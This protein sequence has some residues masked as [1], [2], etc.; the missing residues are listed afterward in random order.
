M[1][2]IANVLPDLSAITSVTGLRDATTDS[3][4][5][6]LSTGAFVDPISSSPAS[7]QP[8]TIVDLSDHAKAVLAR[9]KTEQVAAD[10]LDAQVRASSSDAL[11]SNLSTTG[12]S[13]EKSTFDQIHDLGREL[14]TSGSAPNAQTSDSAGKD[15]LGGTPIWR[16]TAAADNIAI[17]QAG[18]KLYNRPQEMEDIAKNGGQFASPTEGHV[19]SDDVLFVFTVHS[20]IALNISE[21]RE[22]GMTDQ[23]Q[24][25]SDA[26]QNGKL[27]FQKA[28][29]VPDLN[30]KSWMIHFADAGG[31]G[32]MGSS[33]V[34]PT[35]APKAA[36]DSGKAL[37][38]SMGDRGDF[39]V[40]W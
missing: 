30:M 7:T 25:L 27:K 1:T 29:D 17:L 34:K 18:A 8:A 15:V 21:L 6:R 11:G 9:A 24:A 12:N 19:V 10:R 20:Q 28:S 5:A 39:Y 33:S 23:A 22:K 32:E 26:L 16:Q 35:G 31:G 13:P 36:I 40:T 37:A 4:I 38:L 3:V 14:T 2:T